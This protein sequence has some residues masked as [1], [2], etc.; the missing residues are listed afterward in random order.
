MI[1]RLASEETTANSYL[2]VEDHSALLIDVTVSEQICRLLDSE[3]W[4][5]DQIILTHEH[6]DHIFGLNA[7]RS[8]YKVPVTASA[9]CSERIQDPRGNLSSVY[10]MMVFACS[11]RIASVRHDS[12]CCSACETTFEDSHV[13]Y[14]KNHVFLILRCPGHSPGSSIV[15]MDDVAVFSG[16]YLLP[17]HSLNL[18]LSGGNREEYESV[19]VPRIS[20]CLKAGTLVYPGHGEPYV[21]SGA[22]EPAVFR[23]SL[24]NAP[25]V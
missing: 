14:W 4:T 3:G 9:A 19:S 7:I 16:D 21:Y 2:I 18:D 10:D 20:Q 5:P 11:R 6:V 15:L 25:A 23:S 13:L 24:Q 1:V 12:F 17:D 22:A 8:R